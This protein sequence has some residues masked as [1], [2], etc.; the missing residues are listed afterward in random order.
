MTLKMAARD[1]LSIVQFLPM[2]ISIGT[3]MKIDD[4]RIHMNSARSY[5][6]KDESTTSIR[7]WINQGQEGS[8][9]TVSISQAARSTLNSC[10]CTSEDQDMNPTS[11]L[12]ASLE[13]LIVE[14]LSGRKI[15]L[16]RLEE[17][18]GNNKGI[19]DMPLGNITDTQETGTNQQGWGLEIKSEEVHQE[20]ENVSFNA[21]GIV[22]TSDGKEYGFSLH[23]DMIREFVEKNSL[24]IRAGDALTDP[25]VLNFSGN[26][27]QI[28]NMKFVF[29]LNAD[30]KDEQ[31]A[32]L[33]PGSGFLVID[34]NGDGSINDGTE[35]FGPKTGNGFNELGHLDSDGN[36][37]IDENDEAYT[38]LGVL[39]FD[40]QGNR[41]VQSLKDLG[42]GA[43]Y[44]PYSSTLF[45]L[46]EQG[47]NALLGRI[48]ESGIYLSEKGQAGTIQQIDFVS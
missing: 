2:N 36:K 27:A 1:L 45:D 38:R 8:P 7:A 25:L 35:L 20:R 29:D 39:T 19:E 3:G 22:K 41:L 23:L 15:K 33:K 12:D 13:K 28:S 30:G 47:T 5:S 14:L 44:T 26:S 42:V 16:A 4:F 10:S 48:N 37:W 17:V 21:Q 24:T 43:I 11:E 34:V 46:R 31:I 18:Q 6:V 9:D 32:A 40:G